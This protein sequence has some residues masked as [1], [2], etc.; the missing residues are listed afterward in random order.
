M[1]HFVLCKHSD[2]ELE[3]GILYGVRQAQQEV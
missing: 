3:Q 2:T 1:E